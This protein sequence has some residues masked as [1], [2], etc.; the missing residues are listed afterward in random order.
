MS[1]ATSH[2]CTNCGGVVEFA[3]WVPDA[4][5]FYTPCAQCLWPYSRYRQLLEPPYTVNNI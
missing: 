2:T 4:A 1:W 5:S 3:E